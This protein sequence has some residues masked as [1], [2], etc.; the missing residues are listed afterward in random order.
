MRRPVRMQ[1]FAGLDA[2]GMAWQYNGAPPSTAPLAREATALAQRIVAR[3]RVH[4]IAADDVAVHWIQTPPTG[5]HSLKEL[6]QI[7]ASR[8]AHLFGGVPAGWWVA[9]DWSAT[10]AFVCAAL[11]MDRIGPLQRALTEAGAQASWHTAWGLLCRARAGRFPTE[12]WCAVRSAG[13]VVVWCCRQGHVIGLAS[14]TIDAQADASKAQEVVEQLLRIEAMR[15]PAL[16]SG[17]VHWVEQ[18]V[19]AH[20]S[21][22]SGAAMALALSPLVSEAGP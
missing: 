22:H 4:L 21:P 5:V 16:V 7:A 15:D 2:Q 13:R 10:R 9:G 6:R 17:P 18:P 19:P 11:P 8:C 20:V 14:L 1:V 12:G 3:A